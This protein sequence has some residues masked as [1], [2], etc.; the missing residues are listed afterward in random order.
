MAA[1]TGLKPAAVPRR[2]GRFQRCVIPA[3]LAAL[4]AVSWFAAGR[5]VA[6]TGVL[7]TAALVLLAGFLRNRHARSEQDARALLAE[8]RESEAQFRDL[9]DR[10]PVA[11]HEFGRDGMIR[12]VNRAEC[13]LLGYQPD[14]MLGRPAWEF[15][16]GPE[17]DAGR[18]GIDRKLSGEQPLTPI[19]RRFARRD[20]SELLLEIHDT[21]VRN[22]TG[23]ISGIR[24]VLLDITKRKQAE[25]ALRESEESH[26][27]QF[28]EN[29][30][31]ML[32]VDPADG[33][34]IDANTAALEFYGYPRERMLAMPV[35]GIDTR[36]AS[37]VRQAMA[38]V[39]LRQGKR[40]EV[41]HRLADGST[42]DVEVSLSRI[43][44]G[45]RI[46]LH[47]IV[48]DITGRKRAEEALRESETLQSM[49]LTNLPAGVV[50]V[51]PVTRVIEQANDY[52]AT[53]FGSS[54]DHLVGQRCHSLLCP[55]NEGACPVC[56]LG[57]TVDYSERAMLLKDGSRLPI[58][59]T[60]KRVRLSGREK[61]LECFVDVSERK[62]A[63]AALRASEEK[64][65]FLIENSHDIIYTLT[66]DGVFTFVS[67]AWTAHLGHR[68]DQ[69]VGR[70]FRQFVH[71][72]DLAGCMAF[73]RSVIGTGEEKEGVEYRVRHIDGSWYWHTSSAVPLRDQAGTIIGF[74]GTARDI[75]GRKQVEAR[76]T[77]ATDR[78]MLAVRAGGVGIWDYDVVHNRVVW[79]DQMFRL[80]G[81]T[82]D[83]FRGVYE[84]WLAGV[85]PEDRQRAGEEIQMALRG[86]RDFDTEFRVVWTDGSIHSIR[87]LALVR[88][89]A[90]GRPLNLIGTNWDITAQKQAAERAN[91]Y[92]SDL[93]EAREAQERDSAALA[94]ML[95]ALE[96]EKDRAEAATRAKSEF[97]AS[98]SHEIRTPM[99]G[100]IGMTGLLL[101]TP[102]TAE[103]KGYAET[104]RGS[105]EALLGIINDILDFSKVEAGKVDLE[106]VPFDLHSALE[107]VVELLAVKAHE[108]KLELLLWYAPDAPREF[109]GDPGRVRQVVLNLV[110]NAIKFTDSGHVL[111]EAGS[112]EIAGGMASIRIAVHDTG[113]GIPADRQGTLFQKFQQVDSS[114]TRKYGGT[115]LGLA[116]SRQF[117][118]LMGGTMTLASQVGEGSSV[119]FVIRLPLNPSPG[120]APPP[121]VKLGGV[122]VLVVDDHQ[123][124][125][126]V[127]TQLCTR[128]GMRAE[129]AASGEEALRMVSIARA[130]GDPYR[131]ISL[132]HMMPGMDGVETARRLR[133]AG[134]TGGLGIMMITSTDERGEIRRMS[135]AECDAC[136]VKP[137]REA[138]LLDGI[139]RVLGNRETGVTPPMWTRRPSPLPPAPRSRE[140]PRFPG[141]RVLLVEDNIVNQKV[142]SALLGKLGCRVDVAANGREA[143]DMA[144]LLP[145][146]LIFMDC[147]MPEMD[148]YQATGEIRRRE[149]ADG[150]TPII[151]MTA[152]AMPEDRERCRLAGM[153]GY[154][155]K[156]VRA[157]QLWEM[158]GKYLA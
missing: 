135:A 147:Q 101:G 129:E 113:I 124:N 21:P 4:L 17:R 93:E 59:K 128:W 110:G 23:E 88:R 143:L 14:E 148:G 95:E 49:L 153:D 5:T 96:V 146:D 136:L 41:Q 36:P 40:F 64:Y 123:I 55:A 100:V 144:A 86:E 157:E 2:A 106:I 12:R 8:S 152:G 34:I 89:D 10:A 9:F 104:V 155:S 111:V 70:P 78:L 61:L 28:A 108:K 19:Q 50:I 134:Q 18:K 60:V 66:T 20:G 75:T 140:V 58:L 39:A 103:Q 142:A 138:V 149:G 107:D 118:E 35:T 76:L 145:Y 141:R 24:T 81:I 32:L 114:T 65:R 91:R 1:M 80:N 37:E 116:I 52:V 43:P 120:M 156:P 6:L 27:R 112:Q 77:E 117:V 22:A 94:R 25:D 97:L 42:R 121:A 26:R 154:L 31:V 69:V 125:R 74:E 122:R 51:D 102:L 15:V 72:D 11:Y 54:V 99:N 67:P 57:Q 119:S 132:D 90:S 7:L 44:F 130:G 73:L 151:A 33:R 105:G 48:H 56:D 127:T 82:R 133:E 109:L 87:A 68:V 71:P 53:L 16:A 45:Q 85:H 139:Q 98:M 13:A 84:A 92:V 158:L 30:A 47:S 62:Q 137:I 79:D 150:H 83:Q 46:V 38:S 3:A 63:E 131:L 115:G 126:F 29:S